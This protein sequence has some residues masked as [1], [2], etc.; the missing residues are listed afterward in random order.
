LKVSRLSDTR[1]LSP[2]CCYNNLST[3]NAL[4][5]FRNLVDDDN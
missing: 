5:L 3:S 1:A 2:I 4:W